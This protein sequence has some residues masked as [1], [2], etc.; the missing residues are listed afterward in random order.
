[1]NKAKFLLAGIGVLAAAASAIAAKIESKVY[2]REANT[3]IC[4]LTLS[5]ATL[6]FT[7]AAT[8]TSLTFATAVPGDCPDQV[9]VYKGFN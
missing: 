5:Q 8:T 1:M 4:T 2:I 9:T 3:T 7:L 6:Q